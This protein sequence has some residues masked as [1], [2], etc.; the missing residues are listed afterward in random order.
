VGKAP[1]PVWALWR[2]EK[3]FP[4]AGSRTPAVQSIA[5]PTEHFRL[6]R[7]EEQAKQKETSLEIVILH[8][9]TSLS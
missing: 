2:R 6:F 9:V 3:Y 1:E 7:V 4:P 5:I 8:G